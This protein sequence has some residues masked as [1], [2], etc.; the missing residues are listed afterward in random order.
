MASEAKPS[1][2]KV[3][4][5]WIASP[6]ARNDGALRVLRV[7]AVKSSDRRELG[8]RSLRQRLVQVRDDVVDG[9]EADREPDHVGTGACRHLLLGRELPVRGRGRMEDQRARVADV[10]E[11]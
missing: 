3:S 5:S 2:T 8:F 7:F 10:G 6:P 4:A 11:M 1:R 9:L